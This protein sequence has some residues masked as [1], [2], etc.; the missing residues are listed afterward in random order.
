MDNCVPQIILVEAL[1][2]LSKERQLNV[3]M[4]SVTGPSWMDSII[5]F[6]FDGVLLSEV[7]E[8]EKLQRISTWTVPIMFSSRKG[9]QFFSRV[10]RR[11]LWEPYWGKIN[12]TPSNDARVLVVENAKGCC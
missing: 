9:G 5:T 10:A 1:E 11:D 2:K 12:G 3:L 4:V 7:K 6:L 8:A